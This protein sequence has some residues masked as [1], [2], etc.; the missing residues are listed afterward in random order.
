MPRNPARLRDRI[1][2]F[3][4]DTEPSPDQTGQW[5]PDRDVIGTFAADVNRDTGSQSVEGDR[6]TQ[7]ATFRIRMRAHPEIDRDTYFEWDGKVLKVDNITRQGRM[8]RYLQI[9]CRWTEE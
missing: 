1:E 9:E 5:N 2:A 4:Y 7:S 3:K 8:D 6:P